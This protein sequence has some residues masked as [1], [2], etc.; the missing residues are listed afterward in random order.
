MTIPQ[1]RSKV[2]G[3][4]VGRR[5]RELEVPLTCKPQQ[6]NKLTSIASTQTAVSAHE[7]QRYDSTFVG[8]AVTIASAATRKPKYTRHQFPSALPDLLGHLAAVLHSGD[9]L[10][11]QAQTSLNQIYQRNGRR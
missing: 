4:D 1:E 5:A 3:A 8:S 6:G 7:Q 10:K 9:Q 2:D 11:H